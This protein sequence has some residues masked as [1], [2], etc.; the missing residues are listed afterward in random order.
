MLNDK[1]IDSL[2]LIINEYDNNSVAKNITLTSYQE[3]DSTIIII[4]T[5]KGESNKNT[6]FFISNMYTCIIKEYW[7]SGKLIHADMLYS[8]RE[9]IS[10]KS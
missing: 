3:N 5:T 8:T 6:P 1:I 4:L 10:W 7:A 9:P 2:L